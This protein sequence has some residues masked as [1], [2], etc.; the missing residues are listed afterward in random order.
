M[1]VALVTSSHLAHGGGLERHVD[2][3]A[4]GLARRGVDVE[5]LTQDGRRQQERLS[6]SEGVVVRRFVAAFANGPGAAAPGLWDHLRRRAGSY[7][8]ADAQGSQVVLSLAVAHAGLRRFVFTPHT[9]IEQLLRSS[10]ARLTRAIVQRAARVICT[11]N[12][13]ADS[14]CRA[15]PWSADR[16]RVVTPGVDV[17]AIQAAEPFP[18]GEA[19]VLAVGRLERNQRMDRA[20][21]A[22]AGLG[23][24][25]RL[26]VVGDGPARHALQ[27]YA[28]DLRVSSRVSFAGALPDAELYRWL[29]TAR[30]A[31]TLGERHASGVQMFEALAAGTPVVASDIPAHREAVARAGDQGVVFVSPEGSPLEVADAICDAADLAVSPAAAERIPSLD[32]VVDTTAALYDELVLGGLPEA[33]GPGG[34]A[35]ELPGLARGNGLGTA[36]QE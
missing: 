5:V 24:G 36:L 22:M 30:V 34:K 3:L 31:V 1:K 9:P 7:D 6:L 18:L 27:A 25:R 35:A 21:A 29:R 15:L 26:V 11:S 8:V 13:Q 17:W 14:L 33:G 12:D 20:I 10:R 19:I 4:R 28:A 32:A 2:G 16:V 23:P